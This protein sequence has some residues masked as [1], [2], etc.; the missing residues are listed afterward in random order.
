[1]SS[2]TPTTGTQ[3]AGPGPT[4]TEGRENRSGTE[5]APRSEVPAG[6]LVSEH[7]TTSIADVVVEKIAGMAAREIPGVHKLGGGAARALGALRER[8]PGQKASVGQGVA[9]EVGQRQ[10]AVDLVL[11]VDYGF[12]IVE[13]SERVRDNVITSIEEMTGLEVTEVN[14]AV[15]DV[16]LPDEDDDSDSDSRRVE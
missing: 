6:P 1:M 4:T 5:I 7:G 13:V 8:I 14:I 12:P 9:V 16:H 15:D 2:T 10:A 3:A 11:V